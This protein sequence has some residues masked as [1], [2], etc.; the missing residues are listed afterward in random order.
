MCSGDDVERASRS[1][2]WP[3]PFA[4]QLSD[5]G[6][7]ELKSA[8]RWS[9]AAFRSPLGTGSTSRSR[10]ATSMPNARAQGWL[11]AADRCA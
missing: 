6:D 1:D 7:G 4:V 11:L 8:D 2:C 5:Q 10:T 3:F 9:L